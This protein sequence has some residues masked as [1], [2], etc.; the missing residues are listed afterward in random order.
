MCDPFHYAV[1]LTNTTD[2]M[3]T[4]TLEVVEQKENFMLSGEVRV[5]VTL[6]PFDEIKY[7]YVLVALRCGRLALPSVKLYQGDNLL[8][9][10]AA[11]KT[12]ITS[13]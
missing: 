2:K 7:E 11:K 9:R 13:M 3:L 8:A 10:A 5:L 4:I 12:L 1:T 6:P